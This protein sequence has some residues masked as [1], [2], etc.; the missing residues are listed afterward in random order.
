MT[1]EQL[2]TRKL[3][4]R[5]DAI[6]FKLSD[7]LSGTRVLRMAGLAAEFGHEE[8]TPPISWGMYANNRYGVCVVAGGGH[9]SVLFAREGGE[10]IG[11]NDRDLL[12]DFTPITGQ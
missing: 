2:C 5:T 12:H 11:F 8:Q 10:V 3:P 7:F 9:E 1:D 4:A 6:Q